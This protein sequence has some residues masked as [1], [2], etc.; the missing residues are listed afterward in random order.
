MRLSVTA[1]IRNWDRMSRPRAPPPCAGRS[2]RVRSVTLDQH[3]VHDADAAD[4][5]ADAGHRRQQQVIERLLDA[6]APAG[7]RSGCGCWTGLRPPAE[8]WRWRSSS[9]MLSLARL[10]VHAFAHLD[11]RSSPCAAGAVAAAAL[12]AVAEGRERHDHHVVLVLAMEFWPLRES[13]PITVRAP[14]D[15]DGLVH[16]VGVAEQLARHRPADDRH[17]G[18]PGRSPPRT[19]ALR[20]AA[21]RGPPR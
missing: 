17:L 19:C 8:P 11:V 20:P 18:R 9:W 10:H 2:S 15:A 21:S 5:Q 16:R 13:T 3:D 12:D 4:D 14:V 7:S 1:S 6:P